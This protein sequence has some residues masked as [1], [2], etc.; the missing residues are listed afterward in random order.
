[1]NSRVTRSLAS[2]HYYDYHCYNVSMKES[3][4][5]V[6]NRME[7][8]LAGI[9]VVLFECWWC[10][11]DDDE[12]KCCP[13]STHSLTTYC[14]G[15]R[16]ECE[17]DR[18][19]RLGAFTSENHQEKIIHQK[20]AKKKEQSS[21]SFGFR[22]QRLSQGSLRLHAHSPPSA[23]AREGGCAGYKNDQ[24]SNSANLHRH[25]PTTSTSSTGRTTSSSTAGFKTDSLECG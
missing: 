15:S 21:F 18:T 3:I 1:M 14:H 9:W 5:V 7:L 25:G 16:C 24:L 6:N 23:L 10:R 22:F 13:Y 11:G 2:Q 8:K 19:E 20:G 12:V 4:V 17:C